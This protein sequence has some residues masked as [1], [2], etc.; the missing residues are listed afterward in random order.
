MTL[1][2]RQTT[3]KR[4][5]RECDHTKVEEEEGLAGRGIVQLSLEER[6]KEEED[7]E[8]EELESEEEEERIGGTDGIG[9]GSVVG[10]G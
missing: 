8:A 10:K 4:Q 1:E 6:D 9:G 5:R 2:K 7:E 3:R